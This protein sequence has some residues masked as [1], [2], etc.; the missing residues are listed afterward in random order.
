VNKLRMIFGFVV[1]VGL[2]VLAIAIALGDV[3]EKTSFGLM[4]LITIFSNIL[5]DFS[6]WV[7]PRSHESENKNKDII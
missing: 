6:R 7:F 5:L 1:F 2:L 4:G 3:Q